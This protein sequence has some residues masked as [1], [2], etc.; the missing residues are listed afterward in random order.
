MK[1][2]EYLRPQS[3]REAYGLAESF[4]G[5]ARYVAGGTDLIIRVKNRVFEPDALISLR[6][7][8]DLK[9]V[10]HEGG[11][12]LGAGTLIRDIER[13]AFI[14]QEYPALHQASRVLANPQ[15]RNVATIGG[16]FCNAAPCADCAPPL[17]VMDARLRL[18]GFDGRREL[19]LEEFF[20]GPGETCLL[21]NE[22]LTKIF[23]PQK[24][25]HTGM[26][27]LKQGRTAQDLAIASVAALI[28]MDGKVCRTC[29]LAAGSV[30]PVPLRLRQSERLVEG[31]RIED[32]LLDELSMS[33]QREVRPIT[34][35]RSTEGYRRRVTG[36]LAKRAV[37]QA[38][39]GINQ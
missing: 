18:E 27:Y 8:P 37:V 34:D 20:K 21:P 7:I 4:R 36:V 24:E 19:S 2:Y 9:G 32:D 23:I 31:H 25:T 11:S 26:A 12:T 39:E 38:L 6:H 28:I 5:N 30:A 3:L 29:R 33:V 17:L 35:V 1:K 14:A 10:S 13:D 16:N 22:I 15:I